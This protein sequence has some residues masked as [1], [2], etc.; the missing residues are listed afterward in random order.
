[1]NRLTPCLEDVTQACLVVPTLGNPSN[2]LIDADTR[3]VSGLLDFGGALWGDF[4]MAEIF[5]HPSVAF[6]EGYGS[7][8]G[9]SGPER[10]RKLL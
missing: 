6:F 9:T 4:L 7:S 8:A 5:E 2:V 1:M 10:L 3:Q